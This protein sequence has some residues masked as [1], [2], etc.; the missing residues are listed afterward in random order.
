MRSARCGTFGQAAGWLRFNL[1]AYGVE[2][3]D[4]YREKTAAPVELS[5]TPWKALRTNEVP[6]EALALAQ[7]RF[8]SALVRAGS[9]EDVP[10]WVLDFLQEE[11]ARL[12]E[13]PGALVDVPGWVLAELRGLAG[14]STGEGVEVE[15]LAAEVQ[16]VARVVCDRAQGGRVQA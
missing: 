4:E 6:G 8:D 12:S 2:V 16:R 1:P 11:R 13:L 14:F 5:P 7:G 3:P 10:L 15:D 9:S